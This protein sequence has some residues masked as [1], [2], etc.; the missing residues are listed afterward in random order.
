MDLL[1]PSRLKI[2][3]AKHLVNELKQEV[4]AYLNRAPV[5]IVTTISSNPERLD[6]IMVCNEAVPIHFAPILGDIVHNLRCSLDLLAVDL[7]N[8]NNKNGNNVYFPFA[9]SEEELPEMIKRR[10]VHKASEE[11]IHL[12]VSLKPYNGGNT[13]IRYVH[14]LDIMDKHKALIPHAGRVKTPGGALGF[15][16]SGPKPGHVHGRGSTTLWM[17]EKDGFSPN[18]EF[19]AVFELRFPFRGPFQERELISTCYMLVDEFSSILDAFEA[20]LFGAP[21]EQ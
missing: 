9:N 2:T 19:S 17:A 6:W 7:V 4:A 3:R 18:K 5:K 20:L 13:V 15:N 11:A 1:V 12:I 16:D 10:G 14:D 8:A 21:V